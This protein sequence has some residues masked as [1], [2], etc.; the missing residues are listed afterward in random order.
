[1]HNDFIPFCALSEAKGMDITMKEKVVVI[2]GGGTGFGKAMAFKFAGEGCKVLISG[3]REERLQE[4][5]EEVKAVHRSANIEWIKADLT[6]SNDAKA[7]MERAVQLWGQA[8]VMINNAGGGIRLAPL[9][10]YLEEEIRQILDVNL[11]TAINGCRAA[12]PLMKQ[13]QSGVI[14][15]VASVCAKLSWPTY[16]IYTAAKMGLLG[17]SRCLYIELRSQGIKVGTLIPGASE[18]EFSKVMGRDFPLGGESLDAADVAEAAYLMASLP[19]RATIEE[20]TIW[21]TNQEV[22]PL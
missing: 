14:I 8:D 17:L 22:I 4:A 16:S 2:T 5:A 10:E 6:S 13:Q 20:V 15:N 18:T 7:M 21:G 11:M 1:M 19:K 3:R 12:I 9:E